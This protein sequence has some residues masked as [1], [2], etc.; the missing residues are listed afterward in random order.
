MLPISAYKLRFL[1]SL[2]LH[3]YKKKGV[4]LQALHCCGLLQEFS[5]KKDIS[6]KDIIIDTG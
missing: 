6:S 3:E 2:Y 1:S 4:S 5:M